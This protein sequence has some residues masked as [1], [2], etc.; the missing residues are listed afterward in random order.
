MEWILLQADKLWWW[1]VK[2]GVELEV[3]EESWN[4]IYMAVQYISSN[5]ECKPVENFLDLRSSEY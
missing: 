5:D 2:C 3:D 1:G 4:Q